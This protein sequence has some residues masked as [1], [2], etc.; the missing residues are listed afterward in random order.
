MA[1]KEQNS[2]FAKYMKD[3][4]NRYPDS[5][6]RAHNGVGAS[7]RALADKMKPKKVDNSRYLSGLMGG[8]LA[9]RLGY[10]LPKGFEDLL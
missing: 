7:D 4:P 10:T 3:N 5:V 9:H 2:A 1:N 6:R 8:V